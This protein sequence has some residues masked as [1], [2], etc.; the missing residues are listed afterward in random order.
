MTVPPADH[1]EMD[2]RD[3][4][5]GGDDG[6]GGGDGGKHPPLQRSQR[7]RKKN[8]EGEKIAHGLQM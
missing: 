2:D 5:N 6:G 7:G 8:K 3:P 4:G 1:R